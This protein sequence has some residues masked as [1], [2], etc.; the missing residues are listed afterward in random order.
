MSTARQANTIHNIMT[1]D[2]LGMVAVVV[3]G[4]SGVFVISSVVVAR[5]VSDEV[6]DCDTVVSIDK[7]TVVGGICDA[8]VPS[9]VFVIVVAL[10]VSDKVVDC[11]AVGSIAIRVVADFTSVRVISVQSI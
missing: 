9:G 6:V 2:F 11:D 1:I 4:T 10:F 7:R 5:F 3:K 8:I